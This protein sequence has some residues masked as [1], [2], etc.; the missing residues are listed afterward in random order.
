MNVPTNIHSYVNLFNLNL[1]VHGCVDISVNL[2]FHLDEFSYES[3][4]E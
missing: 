3:S 4:Y 2:K 1:N